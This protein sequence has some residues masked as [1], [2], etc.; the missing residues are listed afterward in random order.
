[1]F[2]GIKNKRVLITGASSGIGSAMVQLFA[3]YG[4]CVGIHYNK[5]KDSA[6]S[7]LK[8]VRKQTKAELFQGNL[9]EVE[10]AKDVVKSFIQQFDGIDVLINNAAGVFNYTYFSKLNEKSWDQTFALNLKAPFYM[11]GEAFEHMKNHGGGK[12]LNISTVAVKYGGPNGLHYSASKAALDHLTLGF[13]REGAKHSILVNSI[14]CG[15]IDTPMRK[16]IPGYSE[17]RFK[18]RMNL[19]PLKKVGQPLDIARMALF[20]ASDCGNFIT[21]EIFAVAGGD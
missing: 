20:L 9:L 10:T 11:S 16:K 12:I 2:E 19:V 13:A 5:N 17:E 14:R 3:D 7:L 21:G 6:V 18:A 1:M 8:K 4:A 15:L